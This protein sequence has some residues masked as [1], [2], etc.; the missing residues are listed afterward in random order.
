[1]TYG[2]PIVT[3]QVGAEGMG[4]VDGTHALIR[5]DPVTFGEAVL[6]L[7]TSAPL[8]NRI[9]VNSREIAGR[10]GPEAMSVRLRDMLAATR[11]RS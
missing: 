10:F 4:I 11:S 7:L 3:T 9:S 2:L 1:M 8:W 6:E 5:E